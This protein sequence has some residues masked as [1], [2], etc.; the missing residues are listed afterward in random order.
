MVPCKKCGK[1]LARY[2]TRKYVCS[3]CNGY[4]RSFSILAKELKINSSCVICGDTKNLHI[5]HKDKNK[6]NDSLDNLIVLCS[7]CHNSIHGHKLMMPK[8]VL[9]GKCGKRLIYNDNKKKDKIISRDIRWGKVFYK[10][11]GKRALYLLT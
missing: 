10:H 9:W 8:R 11:A 7:Q 1:E 4:K 3:E 6:H 5:H 2:T